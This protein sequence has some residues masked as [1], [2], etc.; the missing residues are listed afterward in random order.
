MSAAAQLLAIVE[1]PRDDRVRCQASGCHHPV[2]RR[3]H[4]V[5]ENGAVR[6]FGSECFKKLFDAFPVATST[7]RYTTADGR[8]LTEEERQ[9]LIENTERL[10]QQFEAEHQS[11]L[12]RKA[13]IAATR[14]LLDPPSAL[15]IASA[16]SPPTPLPVN[17]AARQA[18]EAQAKQLVRAKFG[19]DPELP[20]WRG[21]VL[22]EVRRIL[23]QTV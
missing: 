16:P 12:A 23:G 8:H 21:L 1:V 5:R 14:K 7:P 6:V 3:I 18:A 19:V 17:A 4:V 11:K 22:A 10:I 13:A 2:F 15:P 20:G 9:L